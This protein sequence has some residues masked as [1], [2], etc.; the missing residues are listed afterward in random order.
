L[1]V[2]L[3]YNLGAA[4][5][6]EVFIQ[7][8]A[9]ISAVIFLGIAIFQVL[10]SL[11]YPLGEATMGGYHKIL[12][13]RLRVASAFSAMIL[14]FMGFVFL[15]HAKVISTGANFVS[16]NIL[17]WV[18]TGYLALNT[19]ANLASKSKKERLIMTPISS[20]AFLLCLF[21]TIAS[22]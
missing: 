16:T 19:V 9:V 10:L 22:P 11:G 20:F 2:Q 1:F 15:Q 4:E 17:V 8:A 6:E 7:I 21:I 3:P 14:L 5:M 18:I 12:P 13:N